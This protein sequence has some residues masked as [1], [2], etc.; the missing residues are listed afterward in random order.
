[1]YVL[2]FAAGRMLA[3]FVQQDRRPER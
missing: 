1:L 2:P 3:A